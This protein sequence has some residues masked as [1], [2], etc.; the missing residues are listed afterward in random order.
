MPLRFAPV[1]RG[2]GVVAKPAGVEGDHRPTLA[3]SVE[4]EH[5]AGADGALP[6]EIERGV[7]WHMSERDYL[8]AD[9]G[10]RPGFW[11]G[12]QAAGLGVSAAVSTAE[13]E[14]LLSSHPRSPANSSPRSTST[15]SRSLDGGSV[16]AGGS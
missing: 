11:L 6:T 2:T 13:L 3:P 10:E 14:A 4:F 16:R 9:D 8:E 1:P 15:M 12:R 5:E 7:C